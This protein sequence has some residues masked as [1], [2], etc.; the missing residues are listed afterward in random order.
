MLRYIPKTGNVLY[1]CHD[2]NFMYIYRFVQYVCNRVTMVVLYEE[3]VC[4]LPAENNGTVASSSPSPSPS[5]SIYCCDLSHLRQTQVL[6][7]I[8]A[9]KLRYVIHEFNRYIYEDLVYEIDKTGTRT[10]RRKII[11]A[12]YVQFSSSPSIG[13]VKCVVEEL[14]ASEYAFPCTWDLYEASRCWRAR[15][16][17]DAKTSVDI[18]FSIAVFGDVVGHTSIRV[19]QTGHQTQ[20]G[21]MTGNMTMT[22]QTSGHLAAKDLV[23]ALLC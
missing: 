20:T 9:S 14:K 13:A 18:V 23:I 6:K 4:G 21:N 12:K 16:V 2:M 19:V 17:I 11:E 22:G 3:H 10:Y 1:S 7:V 15:V 5:A 8:R